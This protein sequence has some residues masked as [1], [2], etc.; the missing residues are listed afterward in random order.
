[1]R[2]RFLFNFWKNLI[3]ELRRKILGFLFWEDKK[4]HLGCRDELVT[5][6]DPDWQSVP[7]SESRQS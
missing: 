5:H 4:V 3:S 1:M 2:F 7:S 6:V